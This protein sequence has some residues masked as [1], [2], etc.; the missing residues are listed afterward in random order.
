[1]KVSRKISEKKQKCK[2]TSQVKNVIANSK[3]KKLECT[4]K[5]FMTRA[6]I[7][8]NKKWQKSS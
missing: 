4:E 7:H 1:M 8:R 2:K 3:K 6:M 5:F